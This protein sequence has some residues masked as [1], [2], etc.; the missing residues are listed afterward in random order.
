MPSGV[1]RKKLPENYPKHIRGITAERAA[2]AV[3]K[4]VEKQ[5]LEIYIPWWI[6]FT[7]WI[8]VLTPGLADW[9]VK[10]VRMPRY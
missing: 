10:K 3:V 5:P 7:A 9:I 2:R 6:R 1:D 4:A 8:S